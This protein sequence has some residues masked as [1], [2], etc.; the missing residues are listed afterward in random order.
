MNNKVLKTLTSLMLITTLLLLAL[1]GLLLIY[2]AIIIKVIYPIIIFSLFFALF[3]IF[4]VHYLKCYL[5]ISGT[6]IIDSKRS[7]KAKRANHTLAA[8]WGFIST[9]MIIIL[10][11]TTLILKAY[12][13]F[14]WYFLIVAVLSS[15]YSINLALIS[16]SIS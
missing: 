4:S 9:I 10:L 6:K 14:Q 13:D 1:F 3:L 12:F 7:E 11:V 2:S 5:H 16:K 8:I 15:L